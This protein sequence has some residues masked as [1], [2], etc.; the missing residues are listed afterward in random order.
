LSVF[1]NTSWVLESYS[2]S[3]WLCLHLEVFSL[4]F[5][6]VVKNDSGLTLRFLTQFEL[7]LDQQKGR[8]RR[9]EGNVGWIWSKHNICMYEN[10]IKKLITFYN[11]NTLIKKENMLHSSHWG[12]LKWS[13]QTKLG[14]FQQRSVKDKCFL[15]HHLSL[16][17]V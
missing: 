15:F 13:I 6:L 2:W 5:P 4:Y 10:V 17:R 8:K 7:I 3:Y 16:G 9:R 14:R 1:A 12:R 11:W